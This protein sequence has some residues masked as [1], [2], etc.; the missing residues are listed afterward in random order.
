M[1]DKALNICRAIIGEKASVTDFE[2][3]SAIEQCLS[4]PLF[5]SID[6]D[7]LHIELLRLYNVRQEEYKMLFDSERNTPWLLDFKANHQKSDWKF[8][9]RYTTYLQNTKN[10]A[11]K[12]IDEIDRLTDDILDKL[13]DPTIR[14]VKGI[15]KKGLVVGQ[16]QSGKT[17]NYTG[18]IC[19][20]ADAGFNLIIVLAGLHNNLRSQTQHRL[21]EDFLGFDTEHERAWKNNGTNRIGVGVLDNNNTAISIT[22]IKSDFKK[23]L[24]DSLGISFDIQSPLLLVV[25][26][27]ATVLKRLNTWLLSQAQEVNGEKKITN[28][29]LL[30]IDDEADNASINTNI[31]DLNPT[32]INNNICKIIL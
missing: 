29:S 21:D 32:T 23:S 20:A 5:S 8:W 18:L 24:A 10:F 2:I 1:I 25:K 19:K 9:N 16:V 27:N 11:P 15:D 4:M 6:K 12:V 14:N 3:N 30:I 28:K 31:K 26:K 13:Y 17:A 22:T 7:Q